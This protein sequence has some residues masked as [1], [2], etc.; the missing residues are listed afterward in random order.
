MERGTLYSQDIMIQVPEKTYN[1]VIAYYEA[2]DGEKLQYMEQDAG[3]TEGYN[4]FKDSKSCVATIFGI[5]GLVNDK[6]SEAE[7]IIN[8]TIDKEKF[9]QVIML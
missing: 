5:D 2:G 8:G 7:R 6:I 9:C 4:S 3:W 1:N